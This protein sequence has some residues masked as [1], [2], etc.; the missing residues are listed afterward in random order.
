MYADVF[1]CARVVKICIFVCAS[2]TVLIQMELY[3]QARHP[4][5][6]E[7]TRFIQITKEAFNYGNGRCRVKKVASFDCLIEHQQAV[8]L[9]SIRERFQSPRFSVFLCRS[10]SNDLYPGT[11]LPGTTYSHTQ[12]KLNTK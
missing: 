6:N 10:L 4:L 5:L 9:L 11:H 1:K 3:R 2:N 7:H 12:K 8:E